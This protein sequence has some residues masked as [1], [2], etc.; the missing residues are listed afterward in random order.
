MAKAELK[1]KRTEASVEDFIDALP[2]AHQRDDS[3]TLMKLMSAITGTPPKLWGPSIIGFGH[4]TLK[5]DSGR[6]VDW[7]Q[8]GFSPRKAAIT[9]YFTCDIARY[10][11]EL[12][13]LGRH[14]TGKG[15]LY[16]KRL[17]DVDAKVLEA[18]VRKAVKG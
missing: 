4:T 8:C 9:L 1:T 11:A 10:A 17:A 2:N 14:T 18:V 6:E 7:M 15:C 12:D 16:I 5:Y 3:R 13:R